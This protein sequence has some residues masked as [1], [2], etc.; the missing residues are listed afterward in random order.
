MGMKDFPLVLPLLLHGKF[1]FNRRALISGCLA[2]LCS[3]CGHVPFRAHAPIL[4]MLLLSSAGA[5][6]RS[7]VHSW[8]EDRTMCILKDVK[9]KSTLQLLSSSDLWAQ[10]E[11]GGMEDKQAHLQKGSKWLEAGMLETETLS[12]GVMFFLVMR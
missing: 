12:K 3:V 4:Q 10:N 2:A 5:G 7:D 1:I 11:G 9:G 6:C 8:R